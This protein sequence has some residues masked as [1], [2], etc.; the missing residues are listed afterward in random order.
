M[1]INMAKEMVSTK[2]IGENDQKSVETKIRNFV[3]SIK[4]R[5]DYDRR[6]MGHNKNV[7]ILN[8]GNAVVLGLRQFHHIL[9][10]GL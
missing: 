8:G 5:K 9:S 4:E 3:K 2:S 7:N 6:I 1:W 10:N